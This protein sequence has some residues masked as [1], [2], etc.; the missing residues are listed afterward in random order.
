MQLLAVL[1][2][3]VGITLCMCTALSMGKAFTGAE[4]SCLR[5][6]SSVSWPLLSWGSGS[7]RKTIPANPPMHEPLQTAVFFPDTVEPRGYS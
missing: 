6:L 7:G 1:H 4:D 2:V 3:L 5:F